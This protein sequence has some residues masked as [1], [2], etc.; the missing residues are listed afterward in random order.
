MTHTRWKVGEEALR[1]LIYRRRGLCRL[2]ALILQLK[3]EIEVK[4]VVLRRRHRASIK[5]PCRIL[6]V[7]VANKSSE[8]APQRRYQILERA[9]KITTT[10]LKVLCEQ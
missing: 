9:S 3:E 2:R 8:I 5:V 4:G 1:W 6:E 7:L 10:N